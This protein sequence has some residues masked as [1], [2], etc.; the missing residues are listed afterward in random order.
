MSIIGQSSLLNSSAGETIAF[1]K[2]AKRAGAGT[3]VPI[4]GFSNAV[5]SPALDF[6]SED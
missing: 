6:K 2:V 1:D 5:T 4:T 3:L